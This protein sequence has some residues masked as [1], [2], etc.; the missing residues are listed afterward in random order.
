LSNTGSRLTAQNCCVTCC[1]TVS[2]TILLKPHS[3][4]AK[5]LCGLSFVSQ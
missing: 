4:A 5:Q 3:A 2:A 1:H